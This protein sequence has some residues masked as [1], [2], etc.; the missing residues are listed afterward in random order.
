MQVK[1]RRRCTDLDPDKLL[2]W[3]CVALFGIALAVT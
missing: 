3:I 2:F 1:P